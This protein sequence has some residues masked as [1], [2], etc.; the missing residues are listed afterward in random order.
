MLH[1]QSE[2]ACFC[3]KQ[4]IV[5]ISFFVIHVLLKV[6]QRVVEILTCRVVSI[7]YICIPFC[8]RRIRKLKE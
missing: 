6:K 2:I 5:N 7:S 3:G 1:Y 4:D 8:N